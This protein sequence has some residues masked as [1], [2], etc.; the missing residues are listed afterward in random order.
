[1]SGWMADAIFV[2]LSMFVATNVAAMLSHGETLWGHF[3]GDDHPLRA[4]ASIGLFFSLLPFLML[5]GFV[6]SR[7]EAQDT[8]FAIFLCWMGL[9]ITLGWLA[10]ALAS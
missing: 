8:S 5:A 10:N 3:E 4:L 1:M 7:W 6:T 9:L 2:W